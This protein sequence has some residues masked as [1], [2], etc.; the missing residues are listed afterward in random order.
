[1]AGAVTEPT[2]DVASS[3]DTSVYN[4][5]S[6]TSVANALLVLWVLA[7][8]TLA[9]GSV[10]SAHGT[11]TNRG[12]KTI[13]GDGAKLYCFTCQ[14]GASASGIVAFYC[15]GDAA[16]GAVVAVQSVTG[17][18]ITS[19]V[20]QFVSNSG[21]GT[22]SSVTR[23][24]P[25]ANSINLAAFGSQGSTTV[26]DPTGWTRTCDN[27][28]A[29]PSTGMWA[30]YRVGGESGTSFDLTGGISTS[31]ALA[32]LEIAAAANARVSTAIFG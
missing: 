27:S 16:T 12:S 30:G 7:S 5:A 2:A 14:C 31:W 9:S 25:G 26:T 20:V 19:P 6:F 24:E 21:T 11:W 32:Y 10:V 3:V 22:A 28:Y 29:G 15:T 17:H 13:S 4:C 8:D 1:M 18:N 23:A